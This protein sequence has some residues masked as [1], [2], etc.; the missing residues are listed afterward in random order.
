MFSEMVV[1]VDMTG[2]VV[3]K[4]KVLG[5]LPLIGNHISNL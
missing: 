4:H 1:P 2:P 3:L 5:F